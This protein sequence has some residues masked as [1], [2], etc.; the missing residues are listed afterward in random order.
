MRTDMVIN[1]EVNATNFEICLSRLT[2]P[3]RE[4]FLRLIRER[5]NRVGKIEMNVLEW[6][7][8]DSDELEGH[9]DILEDILLGK[10][11]GW[12]QRGTDMHGVRILVRL[13]AKGL[14]LKQTSPF[15]IPRKPNRIPRD[16][17]QGQ[18]NPEGF[19]AF[20]HRKIGHP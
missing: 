16:P 3:Q 5:E 9:S 17:L 18:F 13:I 7:L 8:E 1:S 6:L 10:E 14:G 15:S 11:T 2:E 12:K 4:V 19:I 20:R